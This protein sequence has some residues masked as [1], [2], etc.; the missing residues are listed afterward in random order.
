V[1]HCYGISAPAIA[2]VVQS[3]AGSEMGVCV[4]VC[5][6]LFVC[7]RVRVCACVCV[8]M[9][10]VCVCVGVWVCVRVDTQTMSMI[11]SCTHANTWR[12]SVR[13]HIRTHAYALT[14]PR[15]RTHAYPHTHAITGSFTSLDLSGLDLG[16]Q[17]VFTILRVCLCVCVFAVYSVWMLLQC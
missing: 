17:T 14:C 3:S 10:C 6:C 11:W 1:A 5:V 7:V 2:A 8:W 4:C 15:E 16:D 13:S 9:Q 12:G